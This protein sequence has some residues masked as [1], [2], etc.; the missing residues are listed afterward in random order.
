VGR[1][2]QGGDAERVWVVTRHAVADAARDYAWPLLLELLEQHRELINNTRLDGPSL[3]APLH[4]AAHGGAPVEV[5]VRLIG[6]GAWRTLRTARGE[7]PV[8]IAARKGHAHLLEVREPVYAHEAPLA[9]LARIQVH[10]HEVIR[11][12]VDELV[13]END[14]RLPELEPLLE[15]PRPHLWFAVPGMYG[16][17]SYTLEAAGATSRLI[18]ESWCR[19]CGGFGPAPHHLG[20]RQHAGGRG[21]RLTGCG[22]RRGDTCSRWQ[23][24][25][26]APCGLASA[27]S[28][29]LAVDI[30]QGSIIVHRVPRSSLCPS[31]RGAATLKPCL[32]VAR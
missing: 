12:R 3:Y 16:G 24:G 22:D 21:V 9:V 19:V 17:F 23:P 32:T 6:L 25:R 18:S 5:A 28:A 20:C 31:R 13:R 7:R 14:L 2:A 10:F 4:Q 15:L 1:R 26:S 30:K 27:G 8:D 11:G 29:A